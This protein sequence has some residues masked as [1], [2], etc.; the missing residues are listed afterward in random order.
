MLEQGLDYK[1]ITTEEE[2][3][4]LCSELAAAPVIAVDTE[5]EGIGYNDIIVGIALSHK[6]GSGYY[7]PIRHEALDGVR[8]ENQLSPEVAFRI[9]KPVL[10]TSVC[11]GHNSKFD[12][13]MF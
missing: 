3:V 8:Y 13:K 1:L 11:T 9:L 4:A 10:E 7:V 12:I 5:T 2:L 6:H